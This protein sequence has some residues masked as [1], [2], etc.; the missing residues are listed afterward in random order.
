MPRPGSH[1]YDIERARTR[2]R[3]ENE[4][5]ATDREAGRLANEQLEQDEHNRPRKVGERADGPKGER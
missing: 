4:G 1:K 3:L 2:K 5:V